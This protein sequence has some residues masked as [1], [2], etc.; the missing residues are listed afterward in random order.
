[1]IRNNLAVLLAQKQIKISRMALDT[2]LSRTTLTALSQNDSKRIDNDTLNTILMYLEIKPNDFFN[3]FA[4]DFIV[5][6]S[7]KEFEA[8][9]IVSNIEPNKSTLL[10][11]K[12]SFDLFVKLDDKKSPRIPVF[13]FEINVDSNYRSS[14][15]EH[16]QYQTGPDEW[17]ND[18]LVDDNILFSITGN[19]TETDQLTKFW[20]RE[21]PEDF[22]LELT[23]EVL[24]EFYKEIFVR[25]SNALNVSK[26]AFEHYKIDLISEKG[27]FGLRKR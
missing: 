20:E 6:I 7:P 5:N 26:E 2:G 19:E 23:K 4:Y 9:I 10:I 18:V 21:V 12:G 27:L 8:E 11:N 25:L 15:L 22:R 1:M 17:E 3:F 24:M 14:T 16:I 13:E